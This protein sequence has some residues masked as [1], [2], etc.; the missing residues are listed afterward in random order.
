MSGLCV[1][2]PD[3]EMSYYFEAAGFYPEGRGSPTESLGRRLFWFAGSARPR[4]PGI[5]R[6]FP[7]EP[8]CR[9]PAVSSVETMEM[10][11]GAEKR[12]VNSDGTRRQRETVIYRF[13]LHGN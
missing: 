3:C 11:D 9:P 2:P 7:F 13:V 5:R 6:M 10:Q 8:R 12:L 1:W 4:E